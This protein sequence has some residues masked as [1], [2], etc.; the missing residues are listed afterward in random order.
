MNRRCR[1]CWLNEWRGVAVCSRHL[2]E[3]LVWLD[4]F[5]EE[6]AAFVQLLRMR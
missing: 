2:A 1:R 5:H 6:H 3:R 4:R